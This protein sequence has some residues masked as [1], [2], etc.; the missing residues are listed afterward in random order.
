M[1]TF[2]IADTH[3]GDENIIRYENRPFK[4]VNEMET[5]IIEAWNNVVG[6]ED[7]IFVLGDF[8]AF[9]DVESNRSIID[10]LCGRKYLIM[11]NHDRLTPEEWRQCGFEFVSRYPVIYEGF[12]MLSHEPLYVNSNMPYANI[13][14]HIH[15]SDMYKDFSE[16]SFCVSLERI[17]YAPVLFDTVKEKVAGARNNTDN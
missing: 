5:A 11:G 16:H 6:S 3:F 8:S 7:T 9:S 15:A 4:N 14:G 12:W 10:R 2:F 17:G 1:K 13:F